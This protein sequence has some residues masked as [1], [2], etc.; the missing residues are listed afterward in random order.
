MSEVKTTEPKKR[1][2]VLNEPKGPAILASEEIRDIVES[3]TIKGARKILSEKYGISIKKVGDIWKKY[4]GGTTLQD[5]HTGLK[6]ELPTEPVNIHDGSLRSVKTD[7]GTYV[8]AE[9]K[10]K[11]G[12]GKARVKRVLLNK[13][14]S[15]DIDIMSG[16]IEAGNNNKD[17]LMS[18]NKFTNV[19]QEISN[20]ALKTAKM[21]NRITRT[22]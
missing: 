17:L 1:S 18:L 5:Y 16:E 22:Y 9:P 20:Q 2:P 12:T 11:T 6:I 8:A 15:E 13:P 14:T 4:Y 19:A 7:R 21:S 3:R 10:I